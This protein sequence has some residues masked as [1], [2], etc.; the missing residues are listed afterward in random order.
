M[1]PAVR[2]GVFAA[3]IALSVTLSLLLSGVWLFLLI[4]FLLWPFGG[5]SHGQKS[6]PAR[7]CPQCG[8]TS[9]EPGVRYCPR[10]GARLP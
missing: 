7:V 6:V 5:R 1:H 10:D 9:T 2:W 8:F 3:A 4:P